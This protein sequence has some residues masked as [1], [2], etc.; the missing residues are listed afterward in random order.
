MMRRWQE[1]KQIKFSN[2]FYAEGV[3]AET[4]KLLITDITLKET[5]VDIC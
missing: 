3:A 5:D 2:E 4:P 1:E